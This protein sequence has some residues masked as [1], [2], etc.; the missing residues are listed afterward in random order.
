MSCGGHYASS[1]QDCP[2]GNGASWC[3]GDCNWSNNQCVSA[4]IPDSV[5]P[6]SILRVKVWYDDSFLNHPAIGT[7]S[8]ARRFLEKS[9]DDVQKALCLDSL[10]AHLNIQVSIEQ[11]H[12]M[13]FQVKISQTWPG[14]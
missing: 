5:V 9:L 13:N 6:D 11:P 10:G 4:N 2:Q 1:C 3:N 12:T 7:T 14:L 8:K